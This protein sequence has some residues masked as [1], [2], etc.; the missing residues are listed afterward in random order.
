MSVEHCYERPLPAVHLGRAALLALI[1]A[2][3][4]LLGWECWW[5]LQGAEAGFR[6]SDGQWAIQRRRIDQG[7]GGKTVIIGSS[8]L[9][10][11]LQLPVWERLAG[12]RPIQLA[13]EGTSP[14][15]ALEDLAE[16]ADFSGRLL[17]GITPPLFFTGRASRA[18]VLPYYQ[19]ETPSQRAGEWLSMALLEPWVAFYDKDFSLFTLL[20]RQHWPPRPGVFDYEDVRKLSI[21]AADRATHMWRKVEIDPAYQAIAQRIWMQMIKGPPPPGGPEA[22]KKTRIEQIDRAVAAVAKLH[23]RGVQVIFVRAPSA[24]PFL[25][26][27]NRVAPRAATWDVLLARSG[28]PGIHFEDYPAMQGLSIPEWSHLTQADAERYT[29]ALYAAVTALPQ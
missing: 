1:L 5:R 8:R 7:E 24:G 2:V 12:E 29:E 27:E 28:A 25:E 9:L 21:S 10:F 19:K 3:L 22:A 18:Q 11:D 23:A 14:L 26:F 16:D 4:G 6:N 17:V 15:F 13:L 20:E